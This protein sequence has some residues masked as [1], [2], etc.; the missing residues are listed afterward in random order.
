MS[1]CTQSVLLVSSPSVFPSLCTYVAHTHAYV[2]EER[3]VVGA[4]AEVVGQ[5][6]GEEGET[7]RITG[8][9]GR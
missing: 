7:L 4:L 3:E 8:V 9:I 6:V 5:V 2:V 1:S